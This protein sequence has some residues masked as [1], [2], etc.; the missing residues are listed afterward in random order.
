MDKQQEKIYNLSTHWNDIDEVENEPRMALLQ[1]V[2]NTN[3]VI[4]KIKD[5]IKGVPK[6]S[7]V[8]IGGNNQYVGIMIALSKIMR[9]T[10]FYYSPHDNSI[11]S[12]AYLSRQDK[13]EIEKIVR[14]NDTRI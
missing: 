6:G 1:N 11:F 2:K 14:E 10:V 7:K 4:K 13:L 5:G 9:W 8:L 12:A 3:E